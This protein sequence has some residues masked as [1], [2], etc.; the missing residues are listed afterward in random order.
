MAKTWREKHDSHKH[1]IA[2]QTLDR[3]FAGHPVGAKMLIATPKDMTAYFKSVPRG[4]LRDMDAL[5]RSL[6]SK[7]K[8]DF[9]CPLT[10][11]IFSRIAAEHAYA[12]IAEGAAT[13]TVAPFWRVIDPNSPLAK[14]LACGPDFIRLMRES[15]G[16]QAAPAPRRPKAKA[17]AAKKRPARATARSRK[18]V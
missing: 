4:K 8:T 15:E 5:R 1:P 12:Q 10:T 16:A 2:I 18:S 11:G 17:P 7:Y 14:K 3:P 9:V 6:A 13:E